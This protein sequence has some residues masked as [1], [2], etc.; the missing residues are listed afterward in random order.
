MIP[1][2]RDIIR[3]IQKLLPQPVS[4][5]RSRLVAGEAEGS[6]HRIAGEATSHVGPIWAPK[7]PKKRPDFYRDERAAYRDKILWPFGASKRC[8]WAPSG[9]QNVLFGE[10]KRP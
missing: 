9:P 8:R 10:S 4:R 6:N 7:R 2:L 1:R 5:R 3:R